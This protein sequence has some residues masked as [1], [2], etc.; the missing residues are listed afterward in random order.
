MAAGFVWACECAYED[1]QTDSS[2][3]K[4]GRGSRGEQRGEL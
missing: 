3:N 2:P 4:D 1:A